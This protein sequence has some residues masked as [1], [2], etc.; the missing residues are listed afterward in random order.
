MWDFPVKLEVPLAI[1]DP[2]LVKDFASLFN[3]GGSTGYKDGKNPYKGGST[4]NKDTEIF[5]KGG[6]TGCKGTDIFNKGGSMF[7]KNLQMRKKL[8]K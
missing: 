1:I 2:A 6:S 7:C 8:P 4:S 3:K 5:N